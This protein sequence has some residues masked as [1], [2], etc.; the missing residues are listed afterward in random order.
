MYIASLDNYIY[1]RF[2]ELS[3]ENEIQLLGINDFKT[4]S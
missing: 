4:I 3:I 1:F 2:K